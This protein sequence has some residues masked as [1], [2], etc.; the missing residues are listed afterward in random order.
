[1]EKAPSL[2]EKLNAYAGC[3][4]AI[5][6]VFFHS[7]THFILLLHI[8]YQFFPLFFIYIIQ[9]ILQASKHSKCINVHR[10]SITLQSYHSHLSHRRL[11]LRV[12]KQKQPRG[13][14]LF[15]Q[16]T[17]SKIFMNTRMNWVSFI[18]FI[19]FFLLVHV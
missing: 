3:E 18:S 15:Q 7:L 14:L 19:L 4:E 9:D 13:K 1:M 2:L 10:H 17:N 5:R 12:K 11:R 16:S 8:C 6:K